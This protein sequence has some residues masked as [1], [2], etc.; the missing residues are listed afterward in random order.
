LTD[1]SKQTRQEKQEAL[2]SLMNLVKKQDRRIKSRCTADG[3]KQRWIEGY[4]TEDTTSP[5]VHNKSVFITV[6]VVASKGRDDMTFDILGTFLHAVAKDEVIRLLRG[7]L[8]QSMVL[9]DPE[10]YRPHVTH[11]KKEYLCYT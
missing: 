6:A 11:N 5:T 10:Q 1:P 4:K 8:V 9:L 3:S 2:E 7:P